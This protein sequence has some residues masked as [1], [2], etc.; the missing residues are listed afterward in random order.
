M[1]TVTKI[2]TCTNRAKKKRQR[3]N[4]K[5][6]SSTKVSWKESEKKPDWKNH[7]TSHDVCSFS[8][9]ASSLIQWTV[10]RPLVANMHGHELQMNWRQLFLLEELVWRDPILHCL[11]WYEKN[12]SRRQHR[13][14]L[15]TNW[16]LQLLRNDNWINIYSVALVKRKYFA[17]QIT[18]TIELEFHRRAMATLYSHLVIL[19]FICRSSKMIMSSSNNLFY[20][21]RRTSY[22]FRCVPLMLLVFGVARREPRDKRSTCQITMSTR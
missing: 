22:R 3:F 20:A 21:R 5:C 18:W 7:D 11:P 8:S 12:S 13:Y 4:C 9:T 14:F 10:K 16:M 1:E 19:L 6:F 2:D 17:S 15:A